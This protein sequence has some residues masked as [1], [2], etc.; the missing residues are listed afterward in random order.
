MYDEYQN[1]MVD[2]GWFFGCK[3][4]RNLISQS[5]AKKVLCTPS[6]RITSTRGGVISRVI[7]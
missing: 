3:W 2:R 6:Y 5:L 7:G 4:L 1:T